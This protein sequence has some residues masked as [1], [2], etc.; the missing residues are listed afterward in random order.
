VYATLRNF[1]H[2][3]DAALGEQILDIAN[4]Q[5]ETVIGPNGVPDDFERKPVA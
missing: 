5:A 2:N 1:L 4:A 3:D